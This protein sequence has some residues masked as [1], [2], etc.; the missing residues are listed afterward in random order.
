MA[1]PR[2]EYT[3][4]PDIIWNYEALKNNNQAEPISVA[5]TV[6]M[7][8][9]ELGQRVRTFSVRSINECLLG[10]VTGGTRFHDTGIF[11]A[12]Y[13]NEE[14]PMID[15]LL[16][17]ALNTRIVNRF[18]G[19]QG[20]PEAVDNQVYALW[21]VLQKRN[22]RYSSV[23]NTINIEP[24]LVR[25]PGHMFVGYYTDAN[26]KDMKFLETT[27]I[28]DVDLDDFFPDERLDSTMVGKTQNQMSRIT[29]DK[30]KEYASRKYK[31]NEKGI[32]SGRLNYMFLEISK[33]VRRRI[34]PIG[35]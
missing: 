30:S 1:R 17:E 15:H 6:E 16:R 31:E 20:S 12:A 29:F 9:K 8:R 26:H 13:V 4:Y 10:Y 27:M 14:N 21:N 2:T 24:I 33:D 19:Y 7:N 22:F 28:G 23:S 35:K 34:Q 5:V 25:T 18:L 11:F 3:I 32:H